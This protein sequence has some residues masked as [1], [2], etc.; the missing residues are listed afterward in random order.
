MFS[1]FS[2]L[3]ILVETDF[4]LSGVSDVLIGDLKP[5][6]HENTMIKNKKGCPLF[7]ANEGHPLSNLE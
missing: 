7:E 6:D 3:Q 5:G 2:I 4:S 1:C